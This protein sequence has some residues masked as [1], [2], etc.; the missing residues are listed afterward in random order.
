MRS[1]DVRKLS[2]RY[3]SLSFA[4]CSSLYVFPPPSSFL[5]NLLHLHLAPTSR[6]PPQVQKS[7]THYTDAAKDEIE[8]LESI[9]DKDRNGTSCCVRMVDS[10]PHRGPHGLHMC[11]VFEALGENLLA[12]IKRF[13]YRGIPLPLVR[14]LAVDMLRGLDF[15]HR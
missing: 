4:L 13:N 6:A 8:L 9:R 15:L 7:A 10:F 11:M 14:R 2:P 12:V 1:E 3:S 5:P